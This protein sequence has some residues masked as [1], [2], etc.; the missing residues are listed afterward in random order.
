MLGPRR[1]PVVSNATRTQQK[2]GSHTIG[3]DTSTAPN[4]AATK[5]TN[6]DGQRNGRMLATCTNGSDGSNEQQKRRRKRYAWMDSGDESGAGSGSE[7]GGGE[8]SPMR[9]PAGRNTPEP[10]EADGD[11][12]PLQTRVAEVRAFA[13][14]V[15]LAPDLRRRAPRMLPS[16]LAAAV[17]AAA[18]VR[19]YDAEVFD[20]ALI[21]AV[22][23]HLHRSA[24]SFSADD[25]VDLLTGLADLN[26]YDR[27]IF[28]KVVEA[29]AEKEQELE[30][31]TRCGRLLSAFRAVGH[32]DDKDFMEY[33]VQRDKAE[34]YAE[35][36]RQQQAQTGPQIYYGGLRK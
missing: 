25:A 19:F 6:K 32:K 12:R 18:R 22:R 4:S 14:M 3:G 10:C 13:D 8:E 21:P 16:E 30:D 34:R 2:E 33:L 15:R 17:M 35:R 9:A 1:R 36:L 26:A 28:S 31:A 5:L 23:R 20:G 29:F 7:S 11:A 27:A 24:S